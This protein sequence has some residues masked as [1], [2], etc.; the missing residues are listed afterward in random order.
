LSGEID[1]STHNGGLS[2]NRLAGKVRGV[3]TNGGVTVEL[4]GDRWDGDSLDLSTTN[5]GIRVRMPDSYN[6]QLEVRTTNGG[7]HLG[8][9]V[10]ATGEIG[11]RFAA[12]IGSGGALVRFTT[13]NGGVQ[14]GKPGAPAARRTQ[15]TV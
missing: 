10:T 13:T 1:A 11:K 4:A 5:G 3:T 15:K 14:I 8:S 6:A 9:P 12:K 7:M 2:V